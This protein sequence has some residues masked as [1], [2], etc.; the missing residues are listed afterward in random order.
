MSVIYRP[1]SEC[2]E[3]NVPPTTYA[4]RLFWRRVIIR[5]K[6]KQLI[7]IV[8]ETVDWILGDNVDLHHLYS[9]ITVLC[10]YGA[11]TRV[12]RGIEDGGKPISVVPRVRETRSRRIFV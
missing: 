12:L 1:V 8:G 11:I 2:T 10:H 9:C 6:S 3:F 4:Y 5:Q 7:T